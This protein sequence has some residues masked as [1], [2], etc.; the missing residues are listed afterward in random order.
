MLVGRRNGTL[1]KIGAYVA[2]AGPSTFAFL[3]VTVAS[4]AYGLYLTFTDWD[5]LSSVQS[6]VGLGN[7]VAVFA[8]AQF[9][10]S[11]ALTLRFVVVTVALTN[12][13]GFFLALMLTKGLRGSN[14]FK[15][16]FFA[17][18]L[19]GGIV[20]GFIWRF[21]FN[22]GLVAIGNALQ[23]PFFLKAW[24]STPDRAFW[25]LV[26]VFVWQMSGY[27]MV[28]YIAGL[29]SIPRE[30]IEAA[31]IDGATGMSE[32]L[33]VTIPMV[34]PAIAICVFLTLQR[35]F[36]TYDINL[37]LT[38]GGPFA[39]TELVAMRIYNK[40]FISERYGVG[41]SEALVLF[42]MVATLTLVQVIMTKR[43]EVE[44]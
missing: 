27:V 15:A 26:I 28:I 9:W 31:R 33:R 2:F 12:A 3:S 32:L 5:A 4:F 29:L 22:E 37:S 6:F 42:L 1:R 23:I 19:I 8:D 40:A 24:L 39:S 38:Q 36:M 41:Q 44:A 17:S 7:Y 21:I 25:A 16:S 43:A 30:I 20:M 10:G 35:S 14:F 11:F 13:L 18:N 34:V